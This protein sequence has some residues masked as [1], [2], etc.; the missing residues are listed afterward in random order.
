MIDSFKIKGEF[1]INIYSTLKQKTFDHQAVM[2]RKLR[3]PFFKTDFPYDLSWCSIARYSANFS[4][5]DIP[6]K[7]AIVCGGAREEDRGYNSY[8][9]TGFHE[10]ILDDCDKNSTPIVNTKNGLE[11]FHKKIQIKSFAKDYGKENGDLSKMDMSITNGR[12]LHAFIT[13][14]NRFLII[15]A[16]SNGPWCLYN[17]YDIKNDKWLL[18]SSSS[19]IKIHSKDG[20]RSVLINDKILII[21]EDYWISIYNLN[22]NNKSGLQ[23]NHSNNNNDNNDEI[24]YPGGKVMN[25][26]IITKYCFSVMQ[27]AENHGMLVT[28]YSSYITISQ[29]QSIGNSNGSGND[30]DNDNGNGSINSSMAKNVE[31][32]PVKSNGTCNNIEHVQG[33]VLI[34]Q[35][36]LIIFGGA[37]KS[38]YI[39][40]KKKWIYQSFLDSMIQ[41]DIKFE[42]DLLDIH[43]NKIGWQ[44]QH[45]GLKTICYKNGQNT[46]RWSKSTIGK[47]DPEISS[48]GFQ[49]IRKNIQIG[50]NGKQ[51]HVQEKLEPI[52][53]MIGGNSTTQSRSI[54]VL[55][56]SQDYQCD[57]DID[58][59]ENIDNNDDLNHVKR[60]RKQV[61]V[62]MNDMLD[63]ILPF[64]CSKTASTMVINDCLIVMQES[65]YTAI[66]IRARAPW[67][68]ERLLW[69]AYLKNK[70]N[71]ECIIKNLPKDI[72]KQIL[73]FL[74]RSI[75]DL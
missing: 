33:L 44:C 42:L 21:S 48:F 73:K 39:S 26:L 8:Y 4:D 28:D 50:A 66:G 30:N 27:S 52:I 5:V 35:F 75:F 46:R 24:L 51:R 61:V 3:N 20:T 60:K 40:D 45:Y 69:I 7:R 23:T 34:Q 17:V 49:C 74:D 62:I 59:I 31:K 25:P 19:A 22:N 71:D 10:I 9:E 53:T 18:R 57:D 58:D 64:N 11:Y 43:S 2:A 16:P 55:K 14:H 56:C 65:N 32:T 47:G 13:R 67:F 29:L 68:M 38:G 37:I 15:I 41:C 12:E 70:D 63:N 72:I 6:N 54:V 36:S 1:K